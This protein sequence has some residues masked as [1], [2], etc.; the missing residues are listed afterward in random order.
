MPLL[1]SVLVFMTAIYAFETY[2]GNC[3]CFEHL[4][5]QELTLS[6]P[7]TYD[8][9][10]CCCR[11]PR[12]LHLL[13]K[14]QSWTASFLQSLMLPPPPLY[15]LL[16]KSKKISRNPRV[17]VPSTRTLVGNVPSSIAYNLEKMNFTIF[18]GAF[19]QWEGAVLLLLGFGP[20]LWLK[21]FE[22]MLM[23][24]FNLTAENEVA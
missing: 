23:L 14:L 18:K 20:W 2:L 1:E 9:V 24:P 16:P 10:G 17:C 22:V 19:S 6:L 13:R 11:N 3:T 4:F 15:P 5:Q 7:Q 8:N 21:S 12:L